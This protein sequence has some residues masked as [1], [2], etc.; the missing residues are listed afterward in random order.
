MTRFDGSDMEITRSPLIGEAQD[1]PQTHVKVWDPLVRLFHW[2]TVT[3]I[4]LD[5]F[6]F[7][8]GEKLHQWTGYAVASALAIRIAWGLF[9]PG[10]ANFRSFVRGPGI[11]LS[12]LKSAVGGHPPRHLGHNPA[13]GAM[14]LA[15]MT[16]IIVISV[17]GWMQTTDAFWG[18][19]WVQ[20]TH[21]WT[22][23][24][25]L[26]LVVLHAS[27]AVAES[28]RHRENLVWAMITGFKRKELQ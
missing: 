8:D 1:A 7:T 26:G 23:N 9:G 6:V 5:Y 17:S 4:A 22:V 20:E 13:A 2:V 18:V 25:L 27:A 14:I 24:I 10:H 11:V 19:G 28:F 21:R 15:L 3:G 16:M 12:Y